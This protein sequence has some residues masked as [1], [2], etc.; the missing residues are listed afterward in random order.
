MDKQTITGILLILLITFLWMYLAP[1][2]QPPQKPA[3][4]TQTEE[5]LQKAMEDSS[6]IPDTGVSPYRQAEIRETT[7]E[8][9]SDQASSLIQT[10][11]VEKVISLE[12]KLVNAKIS[13]SKGGRITEWELKKYDY[14]AGGKV[15][16][17]SSNNLQDVEGNG[18]DI[19]IM[20][21]NGK[22]IQLDDYT[23]LAD[24][25]ENTT[26]FLDENNPVA[27]LEFYLPV[28]NGR[29][30]K[31]YI[32]YYD[33][34][35]A[36]VIVRLENLQ[37][38]IGPQRWYSLKW[39]NGL[40]ATEEDIKEDNDY[41]RAYA[42][43]NGEL[44]EFDVSTDPKKPEFPSG[45]QTDWTAI[46]TKYFLASVIPQQ[47]QAIDNVELSGLGFEHN[48]ALTKVFSTSLGVKLPPQLTTVHA[49]TF[50][51]YLGPIDY[52][53]LKKYDKNLETLV[54]SRGYEEY[55]RPISIPVLLA[56]KYLHMF[57]PNY[58]FVIIVFS[59]LVKLILHPL[60]KKSYQSMSEM[61][62][63]QPQMAELREKY[64]SDPQR[65]NKEMM[66]LYK[67]H[68]I[69]PLGGCLPT[70]LQMPLL[71]ALFIVFRSTIQLRGEPFI[72][73]ITDLSLPDTLMTLGFSIP[74]LGNSLHVL[75]FLMGATSIWQSKMTMT[76]PKQKMMIYFMPIFLIF[77]FYSFPSGLNL[78]YAIFNV[79]SMVQTRMIKKKMHPDNGADEETPPKIEIR[80]ATPRKTKSQKPRRKK[81]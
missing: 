26:I 43:Q 67:E 3:E 35:S 59:I 30:V 71:F 14:Y 51:V 34:Y 62:Y 79:L 28:E 72:L 15:N 12:T 74:F 33:K 11:S 21:R 80:K 37:S 17:V 20:N 57:I 52:E 56:L 81:S 7:P 23:L 31:K 58:G 46:R 78:Y 18:L 63:V 69:N 40:R 10:D 65:L 48:D 6:G 45:T 68:K 64:K 77:I 47:P 36:D 39:E 38:Y 27:E 49:D 42:Y 24:L 50:T 60:T 29:I 70:L 9:L 54:M 61:Q 75:P 32:F 5:N 41:A 4:I 44:N 66:R 16:L 19:E 53:V 13:N 55:L 73:W 25:P 8:T 2:Q 22:T 76:D 1:P